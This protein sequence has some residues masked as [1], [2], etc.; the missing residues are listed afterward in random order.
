MSEWVP[1]SSRSLSSSY[2]STSS[3]NSAPPCSQAGR[4][5]AKRSSRTH[6]VNGSAGTGI[7]SRTP[8]WLGHGVAVGVGGGGHDPVDHASSGRSRRRRARGAGRRGSAA[9]SARDELPHQ[10]CGLARRWPARLS[11]LRMVT[12]RRASR[13]P[14]LQAADDLADAWCAAV[15]RRGEV[16][17]D[18][19]GSRSRRAGARGVGVAVFGDGQGDDPRSP[20]RAMAPTT[21]VR[22]AGRPR[23]LRCAPAGTVTR[24]PS[25]RDLDDACSGGPGR[26]C[27][28]ATARGAAG[29]AEDAPRSVGARPARRR[30]RRP[31][32]RGGSCRVRGARCRCSAARAGAAMRRRE[33]GRREEAAVV[34]HRR[35]QSVMEPSRRRATGQV[36]V[37]VG[38]LGGEFLVDLDAET[39]CVAGVQVP[40]RVASTRAGT[41]R[42]TRR[43]VAHVLLDGEV[44][45]GQTEVQR[46]GQGDRRDVRRAVRA[47]ADLPDLGQRDD[48]AQ[49]G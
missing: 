46:G 22:V 13:S 27:A 33:R 20:G 31:G 35:H 15:R 1:L 47:A 12:G 42:A 21:R 10:P 30:C 45:R 34:G 16:G 5:A 6:M 24:D 29:D 17:L 39:G 41:P 28:S 48:P 9:G 14:A 2:G 25:G 36:G 19:A 40:V 8:S 18:G 38:E 32:G 43:V 23:G 44:R 49:R 3:V 7:V 37:F 11:Q 4:P 26:A